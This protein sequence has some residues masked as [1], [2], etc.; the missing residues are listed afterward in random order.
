MHEYSF[1]IFTSPNAGPISIASCLLSLTTLNFLVAAFSYKHKIIGHC[2]YIL[3]V[4]LI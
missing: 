4:E 3:R 1:F 2:G